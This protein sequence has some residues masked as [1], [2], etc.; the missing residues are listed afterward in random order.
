M[1]TKKKRVII[2]TNFLL[3]PGQYH[4]DIFSEIEKVMNN[5]YSLYIIDKTIDEL[6][7]I[8]TV[9]KLKDRTAAKIAL[10]LISLKGVKQISSKNMEGRIVDDLLVEIADSDTFIC[11]NDKELKKR[12]LQS[13]VTIIELMKKSYLRINR[14][15][16]AR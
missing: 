11:T 10:E 13:G 2:D 16:K 14:K 4:F 3:L 8:L 7:G 9:A 6:N 5:Q 15:K 1:N 12:L